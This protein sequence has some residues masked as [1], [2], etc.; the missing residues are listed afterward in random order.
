M[1][2]TSK[3]KKYAGPD[4]NFHDEEINIRDLFF[5][6]LD[7]YDFLE[8]T[9]ILNKTVKFGVDEKIILPLF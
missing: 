7:D 9:N 6:S 1:D 8:I 3:I 4:Y 5:I 2:V